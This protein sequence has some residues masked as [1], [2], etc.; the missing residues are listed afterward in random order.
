MVLYTVIQFY[1]KDKY[2]CMHR[3]KKD[4]EFVKQRLEETTR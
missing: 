2:R 1:E 3:G 4:L